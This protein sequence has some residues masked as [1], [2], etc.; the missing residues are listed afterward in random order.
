MRIRINQTAPAGAIERRPFAFG[1]RQT[2]GDRV[3]HGRMMAHAAMAAFDLD[4]FGHRGNEYGQ[5]EHEPSGERRH[6]RAHEIKLG[7]HFDFPCKTMR[8]RTTNVI[9]TSRSLIKLSAP[10]GKSASVAGLDFVSTQAN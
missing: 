10:K 7:L 8:A 1:L 4:A 2:I 3:N 5:R 6:K 9:E